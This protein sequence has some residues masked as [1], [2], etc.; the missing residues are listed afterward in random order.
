MKG[1]FS[2]LLLLLS[3]AG[4][5]QAV[6]V[7]KASSPDKKTMFE[8]KLERNGRLQY[9][10]L[11][12]GEPV[13][14]WSELGLGIIRVQQLTEGP[15]TVV[16]EVFP[17]NFGER[18]S[19]LNHYNS[20]TLITNGFRVEVRVFNRSVAFRYLQPV[21][22]KNIVALQQEETTFRF[23]DPAVLY[24]Y[25]HE[26]VFT[27]TA[28]DTFSRTCDLP[29]TIQTGKYYI[30]IG[31]SDNN[32]FT[33]AVLKK[34]NTGSTL[35]VAYTK[36]AVVQIA[37]EAITPWRTVSVAVNAIGLHDF[38]D[39]NF[40]LSPAPGKPVAPSIVPGKLIRAQLTTESGLECIDFA[41]KMN[42]RYI[43]FDA[44]WYGAEF[45]TSSDPTQ[46]IAAINLQKVIQYGK[47]KGIGVILYVNYMGLKQKLDTILPL[48]KKWGVAGM[49]FGFV[50]GFTQ[51]G[52]TW[53]HEAIRKVNDMGFVLNI[54]D[55]YKPTGLSRTYPA[56][57]TQE[58][59]RGDE[60]SPDAFHNTTLPF[61]RFLAGA[62]DFTFC[63]PNPANSFAKNIKVSKAQQL[64]LT[65][66]YYSP[67]QAIFWYG[68]PGDYT[69]VDEIEFFREVPTMW[70]ESIYL[71]GE[72]GKHIAVAR[73]YK[74]TWYMG[75]AAGFDDW[76]TTVNL[77]FLQAGK[78][79]TAIVYEDDGQG[80]LV[81]RVTEVKHGD[82]FRIA[83]KAKS[84][85]AVI[86]A[87]QGRLDYCVQQ[88]E[89]TITELSG[90]DALPRS[91]ASGQTKWRTSSYK[92]WT[93]G[94]FPGVLWYLYEYT[95]SEKWKARADSFTRTLTPLSLRRATDH[96]LGFQL[97][98]SFGNGWKL[99][100][101][102]DYKRILLAGADTLS[103]LYNPK[104]GTI[105]S[106]PRNVP[107][108]DWPL[109][110]NTII[111][112]MINLELLFWAS[113]NGGDKKLY[114]IAVSHAVTTMK[115]HFRSDYTSYHVVVYDTATGKKVKGITHQ[116]FSDNS[117]WA[118]GQAWAIYG[119]TMVYRE[120]KD[121][122]FLDFVQKITDAYLERLLKDGIPYWDFNDPA[123]PNAP[124]DASAAAVVASALLELSTLTENK[125]KAKI[126]YD[127]AVAML[128]EL[129]SERYQSRNKNNAFLLHSTGHKPNGGEIDASII[130]ADYYYIEA[131]SRL[132]NIAD[133]REHI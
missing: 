3:L 14:S 75:S 127:K 23:P 133:K 64:A 119:Y 113:K 62:A 29:G 28:I 30:S 105:I 91:I 111:D 77:D 42:F 98:C 53:L 66:V 80:G 130:Y 110:H 2:V 132:K 129:S 47:T 74:D 37:Q 26:S 25:N 92:D 52:I 19:I 51:Q 15:R 56:F 38:S 48:Y 17:W 11:F 94:F 118:R 5:A 78:K 114:D 43:M 61:T 10:V 100:N 41:A 112:N 44:G 86:I 96:D 54:H 70:N 49:K 89:K 131:L 1:L 93:S 103:R 63:F 16:N 101:D 45:R 60:N 99:T 73:R 35:E 68:K 79:Y 40:R 36:D 24:Q 46:P 67:L 116:G 97:F 109:R 115:N 65:V 71:S 69:N 6:K 85:Q 87:P 7:I 117:M 122:R 107:G 33:K 20:L 88:A 21:N 84:G 32:F 83:L 121:L 9:R 18:D 106:W 90:Y 22:K 126:Y 102:K 34:G 124:R 72:I 59:I 120:T 39:L 57:L 4:Q 123:I 12:Q 76:S 82:G 31:E 95:G 125:T 8:S 58:G 81:K 50:D 55:N 128:T 108:V 13:L 27:P 104:V